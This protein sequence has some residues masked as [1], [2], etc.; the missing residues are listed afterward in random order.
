M[1][2]K[3]IPYLLAFATAAIFAFSF[4]VALALDLPRGFSFESVY[5]GF[6]FPVAAKFA[7]DGRIFVV[8]K[9]GVVKV[10]KNGVVLP[11]PFITLPN[12][13]DYN[14][15]GLL[16]IAFDPDFSFNHHFFL[17]FTY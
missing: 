7:P 4:S 15:R 8:E 12:V 17:F 13:N 1:K 2:N 11:D 14:D 3:K 9:N 10:I 16:D 5:T 6:N